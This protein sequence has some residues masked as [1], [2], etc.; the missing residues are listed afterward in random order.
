MG[1]ERGRLAKMGTNVLGSRA[2]ENQT[3]RLGQTTATGFL[4]ELLGFT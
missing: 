3:R 1:T 4:V 2:N